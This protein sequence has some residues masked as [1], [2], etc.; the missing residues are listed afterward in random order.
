MPDPDDDPRVL[1][2]PRRVAPTRHDYGEQLPGH[3]YPPSLWSN[4]VASDMA[5][6]RHLQWLMRRRQ[7]D[8]V[9]HQNHHG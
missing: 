7:A 1:K 9:Y 6:E 8:L 5:F 4:R 3:K 2:E